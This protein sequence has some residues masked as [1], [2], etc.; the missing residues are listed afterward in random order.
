M[1]SLLSRVLS[2]NISLSCE[3]Q[4]SH[5]P[6]TPKSLTKEI[7]CNHN[8][9]IGHHNRFNSPVSELHH[10]RKIHARYVGKQ[11]SSAGYPS[12]PLAALVDSGSGDR[13][14]GTNEPPHTARKVGYIYS[15]CVLD[16][17]AKTLDAINSS[18]TLTKLDLPSAR[19]YTHSVNVFAYHHPQVSERSPHSLLG[20]RFDTSCS[21]SSASPAGRQSP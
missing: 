8:Y 11:S 9:T 20:R 3:G 12:G 5:F 2:T 13:L 1:I 15:C 18:G 4:P 6:S 19:N 7:T 21:P 16:E 10:P 17:D 14:Q